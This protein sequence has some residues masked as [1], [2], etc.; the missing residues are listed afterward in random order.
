MGWEK[1]VLAAMLIAML[2][3]LIPRA[4]V[5]MQNTRKGSSSEWGGFFMLIGAVTLFVIFLIMM[6]R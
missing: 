5:M 3:Y 4:K 1:W 2:V 6:V